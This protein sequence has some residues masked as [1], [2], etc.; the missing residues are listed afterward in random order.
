[1]LGV[2]AI[3]NILPHLTKHTLYQIVNRQ[4]ASI[5]FLMREGGSWSCT[6]LLTLM[7]SM[8]GIAIITP[9]TLK[10]TAEIEFALGRVMKPFPTAVW[11]DMI[12]L[13]PTTLGPIFAFHACVPRS[14]D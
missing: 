13:A 8:T 4:F 7:Q 6:T 3:S 12:T 5:L 1:M 10:M 11:G 2:Q 14:V 9:A